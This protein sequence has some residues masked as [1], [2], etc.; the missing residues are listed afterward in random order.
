MPPLRISEASLLSDEIERRAHQASAAPRAA[1]APRPFIVAIDGRSGAGKSTLAGMIA[2]RLGAAL[3]EGDQFYA[4]GSDADW[5]R[6]PVA[7]RI[8]RVIDWRRLRAEALEPLAAGKTAIWHPFDFAAGHGLAAHP[9]VVRAAD[10]VILDGAYSSRREYADLLDLTV[11][12]APPD[13][14]ARRARLLAREGSAFMAAWHPL[15]DDPE[16]TYFTEIR[17]PAS[18]DVI[19][20]PEPRP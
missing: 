15:W 2:A 5:A 20:A 9:T 18:F 10:V 7:D 6:M 14:A 1:V 11:L 19:V 17:P 8:D 3:I 16:S 4:G 12:V 13:D